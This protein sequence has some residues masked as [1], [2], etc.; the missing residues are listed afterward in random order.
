MFVAISVIPLSAYF[1]ILGVFLYNF[2]KRNINNTNLLTQ[3]IYLTTRSSKNL[4]FSFNFVYHDL[5]K[6]IENY[7]SSGKYFIKNLKFQMVFQTSTLTQFT[8]FQK[9]IQRLLSSLTDLQSWKNQRKSLQ[10]RKFMRV[11][12][13]EWKRES[14]CRILD[15]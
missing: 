15:P 4:D 1:I 7:S 5:E 3:E 8:P 11:F 6:N 14:V 13:L 9:N 2:E 10:Q 12:S